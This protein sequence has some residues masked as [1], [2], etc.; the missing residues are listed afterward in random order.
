VPASGGSAAE[1][2]SIETRA[3]EESGEV[4]TR[5]SNDAMDAA[6]IFAVREINLCASDVMRTVNGEVRT[7]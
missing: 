6:K 7:E 2:A 5:A 1:S 4:A 3:D